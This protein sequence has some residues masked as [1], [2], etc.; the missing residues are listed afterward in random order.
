[1]QKHTENLTG[2]WVAISG[3]TGGIGRELCFYLAKCGASLI[4]LDRNMSRSHL[5]AEELRGSFPHMHI[6][7]ITVDWADVAAVKNAT[8][9]LKETPPDILILN[10]GAYSVPRFRTA[11]DLDNVFQINFAAPYYMT[12]ELLP[13]L[14]RN[15]GRVVAVGSI[16]YRYSKTDPADRDFSTRTASSLVYGNSK[17]HLMFAMHQLFATHPAVPFAVVHPGITFTNI[18]AHYP[19]WLFAIIKHPMKVIFMPPR[20]AALSILKGVFTPCGF[21]EWF[22]PRIADI[23]GLPTRRKLRGCAPAEQ[24]HIFAVAEDCYRLIKEYTV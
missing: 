12:R 9:Q 21:N 5:L 1:M 20:I 3:A 4:L 7:H 8:E 11:V 13:Y 6:R 18:T 24:Q 17:R 23:W 19:K 16:A 22:G 2:K 14:E 15:G 10:A